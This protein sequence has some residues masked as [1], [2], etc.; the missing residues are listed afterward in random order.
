[1]LLVNLVLR[2][3]NNCLFSKPGLNQ[4]NMPT[5]TWTM[6]LTKRDLK[7]LKFQKGF[8]LFLLIMLSFVT[9][10][11]MTVA[12]VFGFD[13]DT[14]I[15]LI[16]GI[17]FIILLLLTLWVRRHHL[18]LKSDVRGGL[19]EAVQGKLEDKI[20]HRSNCDF[21]ING[22]TYHVNMDAYFDHEIG[23]QVLIAFGPASKVMLDIQKIEGD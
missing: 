1:M 3:F 7:K 2:Y 15:N 14:T 17:G 9:I 20:R 18:R 22:V 10:M 12:V 11:L 23:D 19:K 4:K 5:Q 8:T 21:T 16:V 13:G 6:E